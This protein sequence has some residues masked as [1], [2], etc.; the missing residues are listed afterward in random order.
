[1]L[2]DDKINDADALKRLSEH[3]KTFL[4]Y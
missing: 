2:D 4:K 3:V 1:L